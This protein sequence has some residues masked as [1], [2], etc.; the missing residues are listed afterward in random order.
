[1]LGSGQRP[2]LVVTM[3]GGRTLVVDSKVNTGAYLDAAGATE[4]AQ[5]KQHLVKYAG[6]VRGTLKAL[7]AKEYWKQF[8]PSPEFVVMFM[9]GESFFAAAVSQDNSLIVDG[10]ERGVLLASPTTLMALL[11]AVRHGWQQQQM[12]ENAE[13]I[14]AA[15]RDL[16]D[17]LCTFV[18]HLD[19]V[20]IGIEKAAEAYN[21]AVGNWESRTLPGARKL[22]ELGADTAKPLE[23]LPQIETPLRPVSPVQD[24][25]ADSDCRRDQ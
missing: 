13:K 21:K 17:R 11:L 2:D 4:D 3:P 7:G 16:Y 15:G 25:S 20:R 14:A 10:M 24:E 9:P 22:K 6:D 5:R 18:G 12:A 1:T 19:S 8:S 23:C